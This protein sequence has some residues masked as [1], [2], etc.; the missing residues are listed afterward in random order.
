MS[1]Y[2]ELMNLIDFVDQFVA[3]NTVV[4]IYSVE[5]MPETIGG[6]TYYN[7]KI[8]KLETVMDWQ[9]TEPD[10]YYKTHTDVKPS[11]Y[12]YCN[13]EGVI[14]VPNHTDRTDLVGIVVD[15]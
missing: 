5:L 3:H 4:E 14:G 8:N 12:R 1:K 13:V 7:R 10:E 6:T 15:V 9:I 11:K 2:N